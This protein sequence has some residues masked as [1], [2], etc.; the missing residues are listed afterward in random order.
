MVGG[1]GGVFMT[2]TLATIIC[3]RKSRK[4]CKVA[5]PLPLRATTF[6][7]RRSVYFFQSKH[8][9][10]ISCKHTLSKSK[11]NCHPKSVLRHLPKP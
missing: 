11:H 3:V 7:R 5:E 10:H 6:C 8:M 1:H 2:T 9:V 4:S